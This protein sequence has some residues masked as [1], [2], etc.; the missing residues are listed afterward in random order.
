[1]VIAMPDLTLYHAA[2]SRSSIVLWMLE[3]KSWRSI[4]PGIRRREFR[5]YSLL[6]SVMLL[7]T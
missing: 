6:V 7:R 3:E 2:P 4:V 1:M 5:G